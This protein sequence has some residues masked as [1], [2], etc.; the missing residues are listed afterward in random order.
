LRLNSNQES[1]KKRRERNRN[2]NG[3]LNQK[4]RKRKKQE[5]KSQKIIHVNNEVN[6]FLFSELK[7]MSY[8]YLVD[9]DYFISFLFVS[10]E[11]PDGF[12]RYRNALLIVSR[13]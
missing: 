8:S 1:G 13:V 10:F 4:D 9:L 12:N 2:I 6:L 5:K 3:Y 7:I 11:I